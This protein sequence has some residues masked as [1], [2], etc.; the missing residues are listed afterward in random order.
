M[1]EGQAELVTREERGEALLGQSP[2]IWA[3]LPLL[4]S[5]ALRRA[6]VDSCQASGHLLPSPTVPELCPGHTPKP[7]LCTCSGGRCTALWVLCVA[8]AAWPGW[9]S[10]AGAGA[11]SSPVASLQQQFS[12]GRVI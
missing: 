12:G 6:E 9:E 8:E 3:V 5:L 7:R 2:R 10:R 4:L 1:G 11:G